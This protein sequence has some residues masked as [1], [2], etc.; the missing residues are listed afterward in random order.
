[1]FRSGL[2]GRSLEY[3][4]S[5]RTSEPDSTALAAEI[6][7]LQGRQDLALR[8]SRELTGRRGLPEDLIARAMF[9]AGASAWDLGDYA[10]GIEQLE[11][12][13]VLAQ[14]VSDASLASKVRLHIL[15]KTADTDAPYELSGPLS[16][17]AVRA[18]QRSGDPHVL[19]EAHITFG[20]LEAR[21]GHVELAK[22]HL[23]LAKQLLRDE[24]N[25]WLAANEKLTDSIVRCLEGDTDSA[26]EIA[27]QALE[28]AAAIGWPKGEAI[29]AANL[30]FYSFCLN[31]L[32]DANA[33]LAK[34]EATGYSL[35]NFTY[36]LLDTKIALAS[37]RGDYAES[38]RL[39]QLGQ[40]RVDGV[41]SWYVLRAAHTRVRALMAEGRF[42]EAL[43][44]AK[45]TRSDAIRLKNGFFESVF[46][47][48]IAELETA[49]GIRSPNLAELAVTPSSLSLLA[50]RRQILVR[51]SFKRVRDERP[52]RP[53]RRR[54]SSARLA[55][56]RSGIQGT[57]TPPILPPGFPPAQMCHSTMQLR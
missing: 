28:D 17:T 40:H 44:L 14:K 26:Y 23:S 45:H 54:V 16:A 47:L 34:A 39:W 55:R 18:V 48:S 56:S 38:E 9:V 19:I 32:A 1:M 8:V 25:R 12:A 53:P 33:F 27:H 5:S 52:S 15:E 11:R 46:S 13:A 29:A 31:R 6:Y 41:A 24:P 2:L 42:D 51:L 43:D 4:Q 35:S 36:A 7:L 21:I 3:L 22:R 37:A 30:A 20:R 10:G 57:V 50:V 49:A